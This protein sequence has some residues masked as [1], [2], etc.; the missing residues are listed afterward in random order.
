MEPQDFDA[1][2]ERV[3]A[4][5]ENPQLAEEIGRQAQEHVRQHFLIT[6]HLLDY[7]NLFLDF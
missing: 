2:A 3:V 7:L 4:L 5:L 6:R 1:C